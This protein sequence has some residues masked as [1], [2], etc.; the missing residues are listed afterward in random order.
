MFRSVTIAV[1]ALL[2]AAVPSAPAQSSRP[3]FEVASIKPNNSHS[4][5]SNTGMGPGF[6][7][8]RNLTL[9]MLMKMAYHVQD[10]QIIGG[11]SWISY[12]A[13]DVEAKA[14]AGA[15]PALVQQ[16]A[17]SG[18][19]PTALMLQSLLEDRF[20]LK[21]RHETRDLPVY[22]LNIAKN[23]SLLKPTRE[24]KAPNGM[25]ILFADITGTSVPLSQFMT[26][27]AAQLDRPVLDKT[28]LEGYFD[29]HLKWS[30]QAT[31][32]DT[33]PELSPPLDATGPSLFTALEEQLGLK[34]ESSK[35][36]VEVLVIDSVQK[37]S[38]N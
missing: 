18:E 5:S 19:D 11:P 10:Y 8:A 22:T 1:A 34:L 26:A 23:G 27:L 16:A 29:F 14:A 15:I 37:P 33:R 31:S 20:Q 32:P 24:Q 36:P 3:K 12:E 4:D 2:I 9:R 28:R 7:A 30:P 25:K 6:L 13:F 21:L 35:G 38:E 17:A